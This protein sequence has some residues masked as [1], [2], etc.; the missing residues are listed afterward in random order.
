[1]DLR[2]RLYAGED[3]FWHVRAF[4]R[5]LL[6]EA[7]FHPATWNVLRW[8]YW[9]WHIVLNCGA[10]P[11]ED[12]ITL[13]E[14]ADGDLR[15][16]LNQDG[17]AECFFQID[18]RNDNAELRSAMLATAEER[19]RTADGLLVWVNGSDAGWT[20]LMERSGYRRTDDDEHVR[21][22]CLDRPIDA[23][24]LAGG[25]RIRALAEGASD[26]PARGDISLRVF[27]P[28]PDGNVAMTA[29]EYRNIQRAPLYR[30]DLDLVVE[31]ANGDL[32]AFV[33]LWFDDT[34]RTVDI[35]PMGTDA[36]HRQRGLGKAL[37][38]E[39]LRRAQLLGATRAY[40]SSYGPAAHA[41]YASVG[42]ETVEHMIGWRRD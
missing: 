40:V 35:E 6:V 9:R 21:L 10:P 28:V 22:A 11:P 32:A 41:L 14:T 27:H 4:L 42:L 1:M 38:L 31:A 17:P 36:P 3:D 16:V 13:Y 20:G 15:A 18:R 39:G 2:A 37:L 26:F 7:D 8:D 19:L 30:R 24:E 33:T 34:L 5:R 12:A 23:P 25:Y 29:D